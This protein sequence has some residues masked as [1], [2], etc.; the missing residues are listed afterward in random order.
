MPNQAMNLTFGDLIIIEI[1]LV[2]YMKD[3]DLS[4]QSGQYISELLGKLEYEMAQLRQGGGE[5]PPIEMPT[6]GPTL[7]P[8]K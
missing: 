2:H 5:R 3:L 1:A 4:M 7:V 8:D 6:G